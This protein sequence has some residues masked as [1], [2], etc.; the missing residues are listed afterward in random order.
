MQDYSKEGKW[1]SVLPD[2]DVEQTYDDLASSPE[3]LLSTVTLRREF[4]PVSEDYINEVIP[5]S[6]KSL[7]ISRCD[8]Y[9]IL[10][11]YC[12]N[13]SDMENAFGIQD[14]FLKT[15]QDA[16]ITL[17][18]KNQYFS[19]RRKLTLVFTTI[20]YDY[21]YIVDHSLSEQLPLEPKGCSHEMD[22]QGDICILQY[23]H[24][25]IYSRFKCTVPWLVTFSRYMV[26]TL[27]DYNC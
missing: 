12:I 10:K 16:H 17:V 19:Y 22:W 4:H 9:E 11:C 24:E 26:N 27:I 21:T 2:Y 8:Y 20:G 13:L 3:D 18:P 23:L 1:R 5:I 7:Q 15:L 6:N 25:K 14:I